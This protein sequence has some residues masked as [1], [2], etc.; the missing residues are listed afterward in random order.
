MARGSPPRFADEVRT[1]LGAPK[2]CSTGTVNIV[3]FCTG[4]R[5]FYS[6]ARFFFIFLPGPGRFCRIPLC[7]EIERSLL[8]TK[9]L[10]TWS[11]CFGDRAGAEQG[12]FSGGKNGRGAFR[13]CF[14]FSSSVRIFIYSTP[15]SY[16]TFC[17][18][19]N[20]RCIKKKTIA[21]P[22]RFPHALC[23]A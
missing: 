23:G 4:M 10:C 5:S 1:L 7:S 2:R 12:R 9:A 20:E 21:I 19:K 3:E 14:F 17:W 13:N 11:L 18:E 22:V 8:Y 6:A 16:R 15:Y